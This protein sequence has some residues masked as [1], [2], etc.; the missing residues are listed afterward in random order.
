MVFLKQ[1]NVTLNV[2][3]L[4]G[5]TVAIGRVVD[6]S[7]VVIE[8]I[9]RHLQRGE[10][11]D[12]ELIRVAVSEVSGA[13]TTST[14]TT[15]AVFLPLGLVTGVIGK[16]FLPFAITVALALLASL[17]V[18][19]TVVPLMAKWFLL[20]AKM[21][22]EDKGESKW[23]AMY[24]RALGWSLDHRLVVVSLAVAL[25]VGSL[26]LVPL[27]GTGFVPES[28]EKYVQIEVSY[29]EGTKATEVDKAVRVIEGELAGEDEHRALPVHDRREHHAG[30]HV[31]WSRR[32][33]HG[34]HVRPAQERR[35]HRRGHQAAA[36]R[37]QG[38][39]ARGRR[40][41]LP[42]RRQLRHQQLA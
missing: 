9:F 18:A 1:T 33:E 27:I 14:L 42:A 23:L 7:I 5:L 26:A 25:F 38:Q 19:I 36:G 35:E 10:K 37:D 11:P 28:K 3:T 30:Q 24:R 4:G 32:V 16:I 34:A 31:R 40:S 29:P 41:R 13:I 12:A 2:M 8:N 39:A 15:V 20:K 17:L 22:V 6:D 21:P